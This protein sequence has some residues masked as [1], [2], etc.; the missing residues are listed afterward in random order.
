[1][2]A[3]R[4]VLEADRLVEPHRRDQRDAPD[5]CLSVAGDRVRRRAGRY[6]PPECSPSVRS[7]GTGTCA[8]SRAL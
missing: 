6:L 4:D 8:R 7:S 2:L 1:V 5:A 3:R